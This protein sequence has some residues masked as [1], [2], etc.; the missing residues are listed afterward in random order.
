MSK[1]ENKVTALVALIVAPIVFFIF[2]FHQLFTTRP[3][4]YICSTIDF[5]GFCPPESQTMS[6]YVQTSMHDLIFDPLTGIFGLFGI[7]DVLLLLIFYAIVFFLTRLVVRQ[8]V[9]RK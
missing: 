1:N 9:T 7:L 2:R 4:S 6:G 8:F 3:G 5:R